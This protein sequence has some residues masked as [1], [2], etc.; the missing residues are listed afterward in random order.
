MMKDD[1]ALNLLDAQL[2]N[3]DIY[4]S[5]YLE[6]NFEEIA[7]RLRAHKGPKRVFWKALAEAFASSDP[8]IRGKHSGL[9]PAATLQ[10]SWALKV[11]ARQSI[12][13]RS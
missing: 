4:A 1:T 12:E 8:P 11:K 7:R 6:E 2:A 5:D 13:A 3:P 10:R 9:L